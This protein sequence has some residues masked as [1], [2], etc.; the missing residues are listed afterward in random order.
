MFLFSA[1]FTK[2]DDAHSGKRARLLFIKGMAMQQP[3]PLEQMTAAELVASRM[4]S[5][6][7]VNVAS[8]VEFAGEPSAASSPC[9]QLAEMMQEN[10]PASPFLYIF[11]LIKPPLPSSARQSRL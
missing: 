7:H 11:L 8:A 5:T 2:L 9:V 6:A 1:A 3:K 10:T 4:S